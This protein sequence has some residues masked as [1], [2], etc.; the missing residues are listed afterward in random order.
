VKVWRARPS[1]ALRSVDA[2]PGSLTKRGDLVVANGLLEL[3]EVQ[4][5][6]KRPMPGA[7]LVAGLARDAR[8]LDSR[9]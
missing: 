4:P 6:G 1:D 5:E 8:R 2:P 7:A 3:V 9:P